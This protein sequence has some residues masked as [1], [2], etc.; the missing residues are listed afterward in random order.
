MRLNIET[1]VG[2]RAIAAGSGSFDEFFNVIIKD[3]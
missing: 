3:H 2:H 1:Y